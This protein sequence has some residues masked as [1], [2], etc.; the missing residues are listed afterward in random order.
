MEN[1]AL[2]FEKL[3]ISSEQWDIIYSDNEGG[4]KFSTPID[5]VL[6]LNSTGIV[7][8]KMLARQI[9]FINNYNLEISKR[10][11]NYRVI[12]LWNLTDVFS[13][14]SIRQIRRS[15][16]DLNVD[17]IFLITSKISFSLYFKL[18]QLF[19]NNSFHRV[20]SNNF[21]ALQFAGQIK[22]EAH[23]NPSENKFLELWSFKKKT[24][25]VGK[26]NYRVIE[27]P[28]W[29]YSNPRNKLSA[30]LRYFENNILQ[31]SIS[32]HADE[33]DVHNLQKKLFEVAENLNI[34]FKQEPFY[35]VF[36]T[37]KLKSFSSRASKVL[38]Q[39]TNRSNKILSAAV[40]VGNAK[41]LFTFKLYKAISPAK[42]STWMAASN[43]DEAFKL[44]EKTKIKTIDSRKQKYNLPSD[45]Y[46]TLKKQYENLVKEHEHFVKE[47]TQSNT[48]IRKILSFINTGD[49]L[50]APFHPDYADQTIAGE[51]YNTLAL[52][53]ARI[54]KHNPLKNNSPKSLVLSFSNVTDIIDNMSDPV[55][56][57]QDQK[58]L[59]VNK[60][61]CE[62]LGYQSFELEQQPISA[63]VDHFEVNRV[64]RQLEEIPGNNSIS[65]DIIDA[66]GNAI[67]STL[68]TRFIEIDGLAAQLVFFKP[69][70][71]V[72]IKQK[73]NNNNAVEPSKNFEHANL[74]NQMLAGIVL[75]HHA[76]I[77]N[78][79]AKLLNDYISPPGYEQ[80]KGVQSLILVTGFLKNS[81]EQYALINSRSYSQAAFNPEDLF[82]T[83]YPLFS[84]YLSL[85]KPDVHLDIEENKSISRLYLSLNPFYV[86]AIFLRLMHIVLDSTEG[87]NIRFG[88]E[89]RKNYLELMISD[90]GDNLNLVSPN[91]SLEQYAGGLS[92]IEIES[93]LKKA[94]GNIYIDTA[95]ETQNT[96]KVIFPVNKIGAGYKS[97]VVDLSNHQVLAISQVDEFEI[98]QKS[99]SSTYA[100]LI[101]TSNMYELQKQMESNSFNPVLI[102]M[103]APGLGIKDLVAY[104]R[105]NNPSVAIIG[106]TNQGS[107]EALSK[108]SKT[109]IDAFVTKPIDLEEFKKT[110]D[111]LL[112]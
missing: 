50:S 58:I 86:K 60:Q 24:Y 77:R 51:L 82:Q 47:T 59:F 15:F 111:L 54:K 6:M 102:D 99:L 98:I 95:P 52:L 56:I 14:K 17:L 92:I 67:L 48:N 90:D 80:Y 28:N 65:C 23:H 66:L 39:Y 21:D 22:R 96:I 30:R 78:T 88:Y 53:N 64:E 76:M 7:N 11:L 63:V 45:D 81:F 33:L 16:P 38:R 87:K 13:Q 9:Q 37:R 44:L 49:F 105:K 2:T 43:S 107:H 32:G 85:T 34:D 10:L 3:N 36:D 109:G 29:Q 42:Y 57:Y 69:Y 110:I 27:L 94:N 12:L 55:F 41:S 91:L 106:L 103:E 68:L 25:T 19:N 71:Q 72:K 1:Q 112:A 4:Y 5:G 62:V 35:V 18:N 93:I 100:N 101:L 89:L 70:H 40:V 84:D 83:L 108:F 73:I 61:F 31:I 8:S 20:F 104:I 74:L 79:N 97:S 26:K 75:F 46:K